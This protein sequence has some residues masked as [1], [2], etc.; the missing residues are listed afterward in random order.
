MFERV[1]LERIRAW[2]GD[3]TEDQKIGERLFE[4]GDYAGAELHLV[5][6][7]VEDERRKPSPDKRILVRLEL[8]EAQRKQY[9]PGP[10]AGPP[11]KLTEA[12][13]TIRSAMD[14]AKRT[15][16]RALTLQ[17]LDALATI[18]G[19]Q[20]DLSRAEQV[21]REATDIEATLKRRDPLA[22]AR[23]LNRL[24]LLRYRNQ[25][26]E[27]AVAALAESASIH[28]QVLGAD[29]LGTANRMSELAAAYHALEQHVDAQRCLRRAIRVHESECGLESPEARAD[30]QM[31]TESLEASGDRDGAA[32]QFERVLGLKLRIVGADL[33]EIAEA[34]VRL[35]NRYTD[36]RRFSRARV[37]A[38]SG[39]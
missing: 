17:C 24:G 10:G 1:L 27:E 14:L 31:L 21:A 38:G 11:G 18:L 3:R 26:F 37:A 32:A 25:K 2:T 13:E 30:L 16:E 12:E 39:G 28:E 8:A 9:R 7:I 6:A 23:R 35:A 19:D 22:T 36:W 33:D 29:H 5:K 20:G 4:Q 15:G 34:Q